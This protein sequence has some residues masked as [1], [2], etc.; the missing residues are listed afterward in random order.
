MKKH[1]RFTRGIIAAVLLILM[2]ASL[3]CHSTGVWRV[4]SYDELQQAFSRGKTGIIYPDLSGLHMDE[5]TIEYKICYPLDEIP[6][7]PRIDRG[8]I[9]EFSISGDG[10]LA[11]NSIK[12]CFSCYESNLS[13]NGD[14]MLAYNGVDIEA[15]HYELESAYSDLLEANVNGCRYLA[16]CLYDDGKTLSAEENAELEAKVH[17]MLYA[18][19][20]GIIDAAQ[21]NS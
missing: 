9:P 5:S 12:C 16:S 4:S 6:G 20:C 3:A 1:I 14:N 11:G 10:V 15:Y 13:C 21:E 17:D 8:N 2:L 7:G 19:V 18:F